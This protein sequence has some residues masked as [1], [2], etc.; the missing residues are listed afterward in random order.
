MIINQQLIRS[1]RVKDYLA[2][3]CRLQ[4][5]F[6]GKGSKGGINTGSNQP[7]ALTSK[8]HLDMF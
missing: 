8:A 1:N 6:A 7:I 2:V 4:T 3:G 5:Q